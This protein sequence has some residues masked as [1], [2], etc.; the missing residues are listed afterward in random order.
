MADKKSVPPQKRHVCA[1]LPLHVL[2]SLG[3]GFPAHH[4]AR[5][6]RGP[7]GRWMLR[8]FAA[9]TFSVLFNGAGDASSPNAPQRSS[10]SSSSNMAYRQE[11]VDGALFCKSMMRRDGTCTDENPLTKRPAAQ[12]NASAVSG[13][14]W[15][16]AALMVLLMD[17]LGWLPSVGCCFGR[18]A[19][20]FALACLCSRQLFCAAVRWCELRRKLEL[21]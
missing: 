6:R 15:R 21:S 8:I 10:Q 14:R 17:W 7:R 20:R 5:V 13:G 18:R 1:P 11:V 2:H 19:G 3:P 9:A 16:C 4:K 12:T